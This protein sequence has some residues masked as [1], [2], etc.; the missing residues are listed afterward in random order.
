MKNVHLKAEIDVITLFH[1]ISQEYN[2]II[3]T[4]KCMYMLRTWYTYIM[5]YQWSIF[6][7]ELNDGRN[8]CYDR[9]YYNVFTNL[10]YI[11]YTSGRK[12]ALQN[13][14]IGNSI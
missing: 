11:L 5:W 7:A 4:F 1:S 10:L 3:N 8:I 2:I 6:N 12:S 9:F 14:R 13:N